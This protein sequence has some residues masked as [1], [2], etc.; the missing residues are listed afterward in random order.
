MPAEIREDRLLR[1]TGS[2][3]EYTVPPHVTCIGELAFAGAGSLAYLHIP[4]TVRSIG[5]YAFDMCYSLRHIRL[6]ESVDSMGTGLF[7]HCWSLT[8]LRFPEG[9]RALGGEMLEGCHALTSIYLPDSL[10]H[11]DRTALS[12]CR[13]LRF[14]YIDPAKL[15]ILPANAANL[16]ALTYMEKHRDG[17]DK[18][19]AV[20]SYA[21]SKP[22]ILLDLAINR[23][24]AEA[25]RYMLEHG[26]AGADELEANLD[27]AIATGRVEITA[28][29]L[30]YGKN[31]DKTIKWEI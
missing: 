20:D 23:R 6:P 24:S 10:E 15:G 1:Y 27:K 12:G 25:V 3:A 29:L 16:A 21:K 22:R 28:L 13:N 17:D 7:H 5:N 8:E 4:D 30:E 9:L 2:E 18:G 14:V 19:A 31:R 26:I 11:M